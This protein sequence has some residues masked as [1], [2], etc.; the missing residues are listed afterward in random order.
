MGR[1]RERYARM[2]FFVGCKSWERKGALCEDGVFCWL[3]ELGEEEG[4]EREWGFLLVS[5]VGR[6]E[7]GAGRKGDIFMARGTH[8]AI[9]EKTAPVKIRVVVGSVQFKLIQFR[10]NLHLYLHINLSRSENCI[11]LWMKGGRSEEGGKTVQWNVNGPE[12]IIVVQKVLLAIHQYT[13]PSGLPFHSFVLVGA[14]T[15]PLFSRNHV[16]WLSCQ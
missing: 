5:R 1:G 15:P 11:L 16:L 4:A 10:P 6:G 14:V 3:Q 8:S 12:E 2:G 13:G 9:I 7:E